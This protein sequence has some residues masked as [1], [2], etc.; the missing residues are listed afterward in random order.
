[1]DDLSHI[2][3]GIDCCIFDEV[4][5]RLSMAYTRD[6]I[7]M[8]LQEMGPTKGPRDDGLPALFFQKC[9]SI[10]GDDVS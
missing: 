8:A 2:L 4:N 9:W 5:Q 10:V 3:F 1:M 7:F 6:E